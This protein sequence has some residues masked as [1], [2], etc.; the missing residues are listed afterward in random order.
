ML[1]TLHSWSHSILLN[2]LVAGTIITPIF[3]R[4][5]WRLK[6]VKSLTQDPTAGRWGGPALRHRKSPHATWAPSVLVLGCGSQPRSV[7]T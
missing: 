4:R 7:G 6:D 3:Q 5:K 2:P 1:G